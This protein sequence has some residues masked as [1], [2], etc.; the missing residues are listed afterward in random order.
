[1]KTEG[2]AVD[3]SMNVQGTVPVDKSLN[4]VGLFFHYTLQ[5][6]NLKK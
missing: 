4:I 5:T 2:V 6:L 1:M 3:V